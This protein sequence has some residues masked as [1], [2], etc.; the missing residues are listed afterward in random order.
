M[1]TK[2]IFILG[3]G[4]GGT[5]VATELR[6]MGFEGKIRIIEDRFLGGECTNLGCIPSKS[7]Y[8]IAKLYTKTRKIL[9]QEIS[10]DTKVISDNVRRAVNTIR[11]GI[12]Y[13]LKN[14]DIEVLYSKAI[15]KKDKIVIDNKEY[16]FDVLV[17]A[18]G[19]SPV[20]FFECNPYVLT[21]RDLWGS[22]F[23]EFIDQINKGKKV[24]VI[25]GG[26]IGVETASIFSSIFTNSSFTIMEKENTI[27]PM[28]DDEIISEIQKILLK[29]GIKVIPGVTIKQLTVENDKVLVK[30]SYVDKEEKEEFDFVIM[31]AGRKINN[32]LEDVKLEVDE[33]L[34]VKGYENVWAVGDV[35]GGKMLAHKA[36]FQA[37]TVAKNIINYLQGKEISQKYTLT[38]EI[39]MPSIMFSIPEV[40]WYGLTEKQVKRMGLDYIVKRENL[41]GNPRA[42]ADNSREGFVKIIYNNKGEILG[43]HILAD[44]VSELINI[45]MAYNS[46][47]IVF[48]HPTLA[49]VF[50]E[51]L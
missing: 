45:P 33:F 2:E 28:A 34:K 31:S 4:A 36:E 38:N 39:Q 5:K 18:T 11:K 35:T 17:V 32:P 22:R 12:E 50:N 49:E 6:L 15:V 1:N 37:K 10:I 29:S 9:K 40:G 48:S 24:L 44:N 41:A 47:T 13:N 26:Y 21:N 19:S 7:L 8:N 23:Q 20:N 25:G 46:Q 43:V 42:I 51:L 30:Y 27:L 14:A 16:N 3:A